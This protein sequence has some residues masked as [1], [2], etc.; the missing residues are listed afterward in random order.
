MKNSKSKGIIIGIIAVSVAI[1]LLLVGIFILRNKK[2][3][4]VY[5]EEISISTF[6]DNLN[7]KITSS[8]IEY[9]ASEDYLIKE[10]EFY[11]YGLYEDVVLHIVPIKYSGD[12]T[13]DIVLETGIFFDKGSANEELAMN[14]LANLIKTNDS[15]LTDEQV[16][17]IIKQ[18]K[19]LGKD[20]VNTKNGTGY[21]NY[22]LVVTY[23]DNE[24]NYHYSIERER[25]PENEKNN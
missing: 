6:V 1:I 19:E 10:D 14:Y 20:N 21:A 8:N 11:W 5:L 3:K 9:L 16:N 7:K 12:L 22:G 18:A 13:K 25:K 15:K 24:D 4:A 2:P 17:E 23:W